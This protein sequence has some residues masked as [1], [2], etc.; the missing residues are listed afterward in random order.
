M[1]GKFQCLNQS[2]GSKGRGGQFFPARREENNILQ[3]HRGT[4]ITDGDTHII[5]DMGMGIPKLP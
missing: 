3:C 2:L 5:N 1:H 4:Q